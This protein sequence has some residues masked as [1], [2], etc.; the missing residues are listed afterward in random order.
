MKAHYSRTAV[1]L[2]AA[3]MIFTLASCGGGGGGSAGG[4]TVVDTDTGAA[5]GFVY[6]SVDGDLEQTSARAAGRTAGRVPLAGASV[7]CEGRTG[8]TDASGYF[9]LTGIPSGPRTLEIT[10]QG[11]NPLRIPVTIRKNEV[12][13]AIPAD[14][15]N[16][17]LQP[18]AAGSISVSSNPAGAEILLEGQA[19]GFITPNTLANVSAGSHEVSVTLDGYDTPAAVS[20]QVAA[21]QTAA[22]DFTLHETSANPDPAPAASGFV[23]VDTNQS[24]CYS[25]TSWQSCPAAGAGF[26]GQDAQYD[27]VQPW[28]T[29]NGDGTVTDNRTGLMW[30]QDPGDKMTYSQAVAGAS[31]FRL[32][33]YSDWRLPSIKELYSLILFSGLDPSSDMYGGTDGLVPFIDTDYF[34]FRYGDTSAGE[35]VIDAQFASSNVYAGDGFDAQTVFGVNFADGRIKGYGTTMGGTE[36][37]FFVLYVRGNTSYGRNNFADNG[38]GTVTDYATGL[39]WQQADSGSGMIW[40]DALDYCES[41]S[42]A[43]G[44]DWRLPNAKELQSIVDYSRAPSLGSAAID[45]VFRTSGITNEAGQA[46]YPYF[47]T[48]TSHASAQGANSA[49]YLA[50]GRALGYMNSAWVDVHGAGAQRSDPKTGDPG[51]YPTGHGPQGDAIRIYNY[52]RCVR[53]GATFTGTSGS[54]QDILPSSGATDGGSTAQTQPGAPPAEAVAACS[55]KS[56]GASCSFSAPD[57]T[58]TGTCRTG[59]ENIFACIP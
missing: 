58:I 1:A 6:M 37:T 21:D 34:D 44:T 7:I 23:I 26:F 24:S 56:T 22:A 4:G 18:S 30:Q 42:L 31:S 5:E 36:K 3:L 57:K 10:K 47:W 59:I 15:T 45:P 41:L 27:G 2:L 43:G 11:F 16:G 8:T 54:A 9:K 17:V 40:E 39:I 20:V 51:D 32:A 49:V 53:G 13:N 52:A 38:D 46:D 28:Y 12:V 25:A 14:S 33:G 29:D 35:R 48:S 55:G 19:T 50:F